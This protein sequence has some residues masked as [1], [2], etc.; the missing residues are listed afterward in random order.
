MTKPKT[1][2][3]ATLPNTGY[4]RLSQILPYLPIAKTTVEK[5]VKQGKFPAP[6]K[7]S[8]TVTAWR[9]ADIH[10]WLNSL[11]TGQHTAANDA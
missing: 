6:V 4:S 7:L 11:A 9:N 5:W 2:V 3:P 1:D 10:A 8:A